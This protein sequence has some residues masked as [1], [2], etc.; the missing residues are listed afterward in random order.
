MA[1]FI[2][3]WGRWAGPE[4]S[5]GFQLE[6]MPYDQQVKN[7]Y[8]AYFHPSADNAPISYLDAAARVHD[9]AYWSA[10]DK[11]RDGLLARFNVDSVDK[12]T[13]GQKF[14]DAF[15]ELDAEKTSRYMD[16]DLVLF[17]N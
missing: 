12:L 15:K 11:L 5:G 4:F 6:N 17:E 9:L 3:Q 2:M 14:S 7:I 1:N 16:A 8:Q 10:E 13:S